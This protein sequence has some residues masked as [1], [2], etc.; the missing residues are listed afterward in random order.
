MIECVYLDKKKYQ[1]STIQE[2]YTQNA[3]FFLSCIQEKDKFCI[4]YTRH[5]KLTK[6]NVFPS[7]IQDRKSTKSLN[8]CI[9]EF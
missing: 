5:K 9:Q 3:R 2:K 1:Y 4:L 8:S 6:E 7:C